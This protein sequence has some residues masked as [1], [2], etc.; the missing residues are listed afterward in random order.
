MR[1]NVSGPPE[2]AERRGTRRSSGF[3]C[4]PPEKLTREFAVR[5]SAFPAAGPAFCRGRFFCAFPACRA[6]PFRCSREK[7]LVE[8]PLGILF[9]A[10]TSAAARLVRTPVV[11]SRGFIRFCPAGCPATGLAL[12]R[13]SF[14][15][16]P[17]VF[18]AYAAHAAKENASPR[19]QQTKP[20]RPAAMTAG[21][22]RRSK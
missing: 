11:R 22:A 21:N 7:G 10:F 19:Q 8:K 18:P 1:G 13:S 2:K 12:G 20:V 6:G 3:S 17:G 14:R 5:G 4:L 15:P 9:L 16:C